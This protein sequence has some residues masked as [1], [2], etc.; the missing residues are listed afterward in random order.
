MLEWLADENSDSADG[1][2]RAQAEAAIAS[3]AQEQGIPLDIFHGR[4]E[5]T[6]NVPERS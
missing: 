3:Y 5:S 6:Q 2:I 1:S 4:P